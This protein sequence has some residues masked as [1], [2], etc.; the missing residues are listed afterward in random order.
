MARVLVVANETLYAPRLEE[1][2]LGYAEA[3]L[4]LHFVVPLRIPVYADLG[5]LGVYGVVALEPGDAAAIEADA[6]H[7]LSIAL[8]RLAHQGVH[9]TGRIH[10]ADPVAAVER[11]LATAPAEEILLSTKARALS[12]WL[13]M[14]L[15]RRLS[16]RFP[17]HR[18]TTVENRARELAGAR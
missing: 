7:R 6:R 1:V 17:T 10:A 14:D 5:G 18:I 2:L 11:E 8:E 12:R 15:P 3:G 9:A 16:R 4:E 13:G